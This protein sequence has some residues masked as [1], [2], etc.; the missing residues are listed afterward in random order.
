MDWAGTIKKSVCSGM[1]QLPFNCSSTVVYLNFWHLI[2][3]GAVFAIVFLSARILFYNHPARNMERVSANTYA[4]RG[5]IAKTSTLQLNPYVM[6][7]ALGEQLPKENGIRALARSLNEKYEDKYFIVEFREQEARM[8]RTELRLRA[9]SWNFPKEQFRTDPFTLGR[10]KKESVSLD[11]DD[12][13]DNVGAIGD[14]QIYIR[15]VRVWDIR[16][17]LNHPNRE[18]RL[19]I[20]VALFVAFLEYSSDVAKLI[21]T[22]LFAN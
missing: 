12:T 9:T 6:A 16:H 13:S 21:R 7:E 15:R 20:R 22:L 2:V 11:D 8:F 14:F 4:A 5:S 1:E 10:I 17:W 18:Q 3:V 19:A